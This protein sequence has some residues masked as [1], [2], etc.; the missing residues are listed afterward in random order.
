MS[1]LSKKSFVLGLTIG[2]VV[3]GMSLVFANTQ[4]QAILNNQIKITL[5]GQVQEFRDETTNEVQYPI[6]YHNR[7]YLPLRNVAQLAGL[8]VDYDANTNTAIL[9][10]N[11]TIEDSKVSLDNLRVDLDPNDGVENLIVM[12]KEQEVGVNGATFIV[13]CDKSGE[14]VKIGE[15]QA[16]GVEGPDYYVENGIIY[17]DY[18]AYLESPAPITSYSLKNG[19][20]EKKDCTLE[21]IN[22]ENT[23]SFDEWL[24]IKT[25][26]GD[27]SNAELGYILKKGDKV[28]IKEIN[29]TQNRMEITLEKEDSSKIIVVY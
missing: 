14:Q 10:S 16:R 4:I 15:F 6:T 17:T 8:K 26:D 23:I 5:D 13:Y 28:T 24:T 9:T 27:V 20:L 22:K 7:T 2:I 12:D 21:N 29:K 11:K 18:I 19:I 3:A 1:K 25:P